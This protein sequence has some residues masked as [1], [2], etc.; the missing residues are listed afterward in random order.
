M[1]RT[2]RKF[3]A[4]VAI[5]SC[6]LNSSSYAQ[7]VR[8][9][10]AKV[11]P[12]AEWG[13]VVVKG[14][15]GNLSAPAY[16]DI[17]MGKERWQKVPV[18]DGVF[19]YRKE[20][21]LPAYG[22]IMVKYNSEGGPFSNMTLVNM[23]FDKGTM[24]LHSTSDSI[25]TGTIRMT[26]SGSW[27]FN[28]YQDFWNKEG[29]IVRKQRELAAEFNKATPEQL[30]SEQFIREYERK[31]EVLL[32]RWDAMMFEEADKYPDA[33]HTGIAFSGYLKHR[34]PDEAT[35]LKF[36][37][38]YGE[39]I[40]RRAMRYL[41]KIGEDGGILI[42]GKVTGSPE[43]LSAIDTVM[44]SK[45]DRTGRS[46]TAAVKNG[47]FQC[48][49]PEDMS[50]Y[51]IVTYSS[52]KADAGRNSAR[53]YMISKSFMIEDTVSI[54]I[55]R[56]SR[57][58]H[59]EGGRQNQASDIYAAERAILTRKR[60][61]LLDSKAS[62]L[63]DSLT[64]SKQ[65]ALLDEEMDKQ[66]TEFIAAHPYAWK[67]M[68]LLVDLIKAYQAKPWRDDPEGKELK[69][70]EKLYASLDNS[71]QERGGFFPELLQNIEAAR[72]P[73]FT[74]EMPDGTIFNLDDL[75][76]K[77]FLIDFW[78]SWCG[79]CRKGHPHMKELY[80]KYKDKGF[81][82]VGVGVENGSREEQW[83]KF[84]KAIA[85]DEV[86]WLQ[87]LNDPSKQDLTKIYGVPFFP[88]KILVNRKG[89]VMLTVD[90][91]EERRLDAKLK[92]LFGGS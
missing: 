45:I 79:P 82:I 69:E 58:I 63:I 34:E 74:G 44:I 53:Q 89:K 49:V 19:E 27:I 12:D 15:I 38:K 23:F 54:V 83:R 21:W 30:Q 70:Y 46:A 14:R 66:I 37:E 57:K 86:P 4:A 22:A 26:G 9:Q 6:F 2:G 91:D 81:E 77:V 85:E 5:A 92:E 51:A 78:G 10:T 87:V 17:Y 16:V 13:E 59:I 56:N 90:S 7:Q 55:D 67:S 28:R 60:N 42:K 20:T 71:V 1:K 11:A 61:D 76:G 75:K 41:E 73:S 88:F 62:G 35:V 43:T 72:V 65:R 80:A 47:T 32:K 25:K 8:P 24:E 33:M 52:Y 50:G 68:D 40:K 18:K 31:N 64:Y 84:K 36:A 48:R 3:L 29:E 39:S